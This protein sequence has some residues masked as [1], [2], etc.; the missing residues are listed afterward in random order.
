MTVEA[1]GYITD[2]DPTQ[3]V[4]TDGKREGDNHFRNFKKS[5]QDSFPNISGAMT[6]THTQL[7]IMDG[8]TATTAELNY[9]DITTLG[10]A[11]A[12]KAVTCDASKDVIGLN[13]VTSTAF[14]GALTGNASTATTATTAS[15]ITSQGALA[16]L[17][18]VAAGQIDADSVQ[19]SEIN[20]ASTD[21]SVA[22]WSSATGA[23]TIPEGIWWIHMA[24]T[25]IDLEVQ[26]NSSWVMVFDTGVE[27]VGATMAYSDGTNMR[28][29]NSASLT[30]TIYG[31][32]LT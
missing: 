9:N 10:T 13:S 16:T 23:R 32:R 25:N 15:T 19:A 1:P 27:G 21:T 26:I 22:S 18:S 2:I 3:P 14:V 30:I 29:N 17:D 8:V 24:N 5:V 7:N 28:L 6:A 11:Q 4:G 12:S 31:R 20:F